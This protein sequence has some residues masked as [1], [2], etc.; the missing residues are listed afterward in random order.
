MTFFLDNNLSDRIAKGLRGFGEDARHLKEHF[1]TDA[2]DCEWLPEVAQR[3]WFVLTRDLG[4]H[5]KPLEL[6]LIKRH[7][8]GVFVVTGRHLKAWDLIV[9]IVRK[10]PDI[11]RQAQALS[12]PFLL[13]VRARGQIRRLP[14]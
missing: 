10:W 13:E 6:A 9:L 5:T 14:L 1:P 11:R 8:A 7:G 4:L 3:G 2:E 12:R